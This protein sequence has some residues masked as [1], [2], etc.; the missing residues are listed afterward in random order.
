MENRS[1][2]FYFFHLPLGFCEIQ[3]ERRDD[4]FQITAQSCLLVLHELN[5]MKGSMLN[6]M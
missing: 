6:I 5:E 4:M 3:N 2:D 1:P